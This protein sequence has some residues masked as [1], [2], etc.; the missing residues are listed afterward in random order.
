MRDATHG[1]RGEVESLGGVA[2][3]SRSLFFIYSHCFSLFQKSKILGKLEDD[4]R[5][6]EHLL[7]VADRQSMSD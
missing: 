3:I 5:L 4:A 2:W 7:G 6:L 1:G